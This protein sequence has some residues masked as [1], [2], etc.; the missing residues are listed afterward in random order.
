M[1]MEEHKIILVWA[2]HRAHAMMLELQTMIGLSQ[3]VAMDLKVQ[4][5]RTIQ[6]LYTRSRNT[7]GWFAL[8]KQQEKLWAF[9]PRQEKM[10][11]ITVGD[12]MLRCKPALTNKGEFILLRTRFSRVTITEIPG[13]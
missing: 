2:A 10:K 7:V 12:G 9:N 1:Y 5:T 11:T 8:I 6:T 3:M 13:K 4:L